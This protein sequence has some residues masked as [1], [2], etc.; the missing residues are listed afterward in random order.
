MSEIAHALD[1]AEIDT[2]EREES[3]YGVYVT[4]I[5]TSTEAAPS[6]AFASILAP[7]R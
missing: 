1:K 2:G 3:R 4:A 5:V 7:N 6:S